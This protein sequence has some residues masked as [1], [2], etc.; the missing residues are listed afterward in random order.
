M[1]ESGLLGTGDDDLIDTVRCHRASVSE[2]EFRPELWLG[3]AGP[4]T[5]NGVYQ[6]IVT[7]AE[8]AGLGHIKPHQFRHSFAHAWLAG[9]GGETDLMRLTGWQSRSMLMRY[10]ASAADERARAAYHERSP[11]DRL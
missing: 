8:Q 4:M 7:R 6:V 10:G 3:H 5:P 2:P 11:G 1:S 9:G